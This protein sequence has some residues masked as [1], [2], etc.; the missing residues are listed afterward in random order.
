MKDPVKFLINLFKIAVDSVHPSNC[1]PRC[2]PKKPSG[3][4]ILIG[5]GKASAAMAE[6]VE[7]HWMPPLEGLVITRKKFSRPCKNIEVIEASHPISNNVGLV[8]SKRILKMVTNLNKQDSV[9]CLI[10]GG[11]S[12]LL[13]VPAPG[14][15]FSEK[16]D[17]NS[18]LI[19]SGA[20]ISEINIVRKHLSA[21]KGGRLA[22]ACRPANL[23]TLIISDVCGDD[24]SLVASGPTIADFSLPSDALRILKKYD[25]QTSKTIIQ[26]LNALE[27]QDRTRIESHGSYQM[28]ASAK[29]LLSAAAE[30]ARKN[31]FGV[32]ILGDAIQGEA[33]EVG[34][35]MGR[36]ALRESRK[37]HLMISGGETTVTVKGRGSG[38]PNQEFL[39][40]LVLELNGR[41]N[42]YALS[43]DTD[44]IDGSRDNAGAFITPDTLLRG[45]QLGCN[46]K[47]ALR[48]NDSY[49]YFRKL[50]DIVKT[51]ATFTNVNDF[52]AILM[53]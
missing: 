6:E 2:L 46:A 35:L 40:G 44:G 34:K 53:L 31:G 10:S 42:V 1:I 13:T 20:P 50:G 9:L 47:D 15:E 17:L 3:R 8:S 36:K 16:Q 41:P 11:G 23:H 43:C 49:T 27:E 37:P 48:R 51:G 33:R 12:A 52:R 5:A 4:T 30:H 18:S 29:N 38:G 25:I 39:L 32:T 24:P 45:E 14:I 22:L 7:K 21:V 19:N 26:Y 28:I